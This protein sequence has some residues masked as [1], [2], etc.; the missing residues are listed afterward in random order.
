MLRYAMV[1]FTEIDD[2]LYVAN[3]IGLFTRALVQGTKSMRDHAGDS[4]SRQTYLS[5]VQWREVTYNI[6]FSLFD[7]NNF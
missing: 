7:Y 6:T 4:A 1:R 5:L 2:M 3:M